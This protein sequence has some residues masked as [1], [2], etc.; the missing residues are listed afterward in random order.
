MLFRNRFFRSP[1]SFGSVIAALTI[2]AA[3]AP[4]AVTSITGSTSDYNVVAA[5]TVSSTSIGAATL[6]IGGG[7]SS[8][9]TSQAGILIFTL[10]TIASGQSVGPLTSLTITL[11]STGANISMNGDVWGVGNFPT[12]LPPGT[13][14]TTVPNN[15]NFFSNKDDGSGNANATATDTKIVDNFLTPATGTTGAVLSTP[16]GASNAL[17]SYIQLFYT[18]NPS[19]D[20]SAGQAYVY[21]RINPDGSATSSSNR[22]LVDSANNGAALQPVLSLD[23]VSGASVPEPSVYGLMIGGGVV[24]LGVR[25]AR[26]SR[27]A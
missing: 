3:Q 7:G 22:Y 2:A 26:R 1:W 25:Q 23:I 4:A 19:Y 11:G 6:A 27:V 24:L 8:P 20:A 15:F 21:L 12:A 17:Q 18:A 5:G 14:A 10:P 16:T 13:G 9:A